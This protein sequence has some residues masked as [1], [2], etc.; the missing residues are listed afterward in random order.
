MKKIIFTC[1][2]FFSSLFLSTAIVNAS[3]DSEQVDYSIQPILPENQIDRGNSFYDL[4]VNPGDK[5]TIKLQI[6]NFSEAEQSFTIHVNPAETNGNL[7]IDYSGSRKENLQE[8]KIKINEIVKAPESVTIPGGK[9]GIVSLELSLPKEE[10]AGVILGGI[11]VKK[12]LPDKKEAGLSTDYD[13]ILGMMLSESDEEIKP[14]LKFVSVSPGVITNNAGLLVKMKNIHPM[15]SNKVHM[16]GNVYKTAD[17]KQ[18]VITREIK[19]GGIAPDSDFQINFFNGSV[20]ATEPLDAGDYLLKL[21]FTDAAGNNWH[22]EK[23]FSITKK[24]AEAINTK[25]F[26]VKKDNSLLFVIIGVLTAILLIL[27]VLIIVYL[28][29][30]KREE[31]E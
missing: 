14:E 15:Y 21:D 18:A 29:R 3:D 27:L 26:T 11:Q 19:D 12:A 1:L 25:V 6:N 30:R 8:G 13:Y 4:R 5:Q 31:S 24:E 2:V 16:V 23:E 28:S 17:K 22:F 9:T 20:G 10:F 7:M